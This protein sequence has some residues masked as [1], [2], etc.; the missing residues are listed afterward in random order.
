MTI[1]EAYSVG[2]PVIGSDKGN[3][4]CLI[5]NGVTGWI[6]ECG[7][8]RKL[9][10]VIKKTLNNQVQ[11]EMKFQNKYNVQENYKILSNI[12]WCICKEK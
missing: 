4:G 11:F 8:A 12:Y 6:F 3:V 2:T 9:M 1:V 10:N 7:N 5:E